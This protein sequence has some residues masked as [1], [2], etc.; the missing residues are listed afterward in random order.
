VDL[1]AQAAAADLAARTV[2]TKKSFPAK[3]LAANIGIKNVSPK[4]K[5]T[6]SIAKSSK[7]VCSKSGSKIKTLSVGNCV[8]TF[9]VQEPK[10]KKGKKPKATKTVKTLLVQ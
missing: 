3:S 5:V 6:F 4:A 7:K 2:G 10:P 9:T 1:V 8:V